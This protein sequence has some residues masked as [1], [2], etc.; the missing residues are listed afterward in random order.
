MT[1]LDL[2]EGTSICIGH[3]KSLTSI[4]HIPINT[5]VEIL[6]KS[7]YNYLIFKYSKKLLLLNDSPFGKYSIYI[8]LKTFPAI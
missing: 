2:F 5:N 6:M 4:L 3:N 8:L 7:A 1:F